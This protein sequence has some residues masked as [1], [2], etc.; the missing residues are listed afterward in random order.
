MLGHE[1]HIGADGKIVV[2]YQ[3]DLN[4]T[5]TEYVGLKQIE[6]YPNP[7]SGKLNI[8]GIESGN[9]IQIYN[10][11]GSIISDRKAL[12]NLEI[13]TL[14]NIPSGMFLIVISN[15]NKMLGRFKAI[16]Y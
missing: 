5:S 6:I 1:V 2:M 12:S 3:L 16:K 10:A 4:V 11:T 15:D 14:E 13:I 7:T 8:S 9:R